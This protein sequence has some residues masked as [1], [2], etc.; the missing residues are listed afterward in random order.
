[1]N[2]TPSISEVIDEL[3]ISVSASSKK[4][5]QIRSSSFWKKFKFKRRTKERIESVKKNLADKR[6]QF[7][8][9]E[10]L[11]GCEK[12]D[13][14]I[15]FQLISAKSLE[16]DKKTLKEKEDSTGF[17]LDDIKNKLD[18]LA[19]INTLEIGEAYTF[20]IMFAEF[21]RNDMPNYELFPDVFGATRSNW[22]YH[23]AGVMS[24]I[25]KVLDLTC[26]FE[27]LGKRDAVIE[28]R[29]ENAEIILIAE[30]EWDYNTIFGDKNELKKLKKSCQENLSAQAFL[31]TY[32][33]NV[34]YLDYLEEIAK[35]WISETE[36]EDNSAT[37]FLHIII[38]EEKVNYR[39][40][41]TLKSI[42]IHQ[43]G[44]DIL[45]EKSLQV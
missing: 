22:T 10:S 5:R 20:S 8:L 29:G 2:K 7:N 28:T 45:G 23:T 11:F 40:F 32:C 26:K 41:Q 27:S 14:L 16:N 30:W 24:Q 18:Y 15:V 31:L 6:L 42:A 17:K 4:Q 39:E 21:F 34:K 12:R 9:E 1:M 37:L 13:Q 35:F 33:P 25:C 36:S 38:F 3:Y 44:I 19:E 43:T